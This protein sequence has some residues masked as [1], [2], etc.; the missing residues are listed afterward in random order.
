MSTL[1]KSLAMVTVYLDFL[2]MAR[3]F[4]KIGFQYGN[5]MS[6]KLRPSMLSAWVLKVLLYTCTV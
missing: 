4:D 2:Q 5:G 1:M 3:S 6:K